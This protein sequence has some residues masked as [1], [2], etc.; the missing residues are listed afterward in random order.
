[1]AI[2]DEGCGQSVIRELAPQKI[3]VSGQGGCG[4]VAQMRRQ[5]CSRRG[6]FVNLLGRGGGM[7]ESHMNATLY[8]GRY[9]INCAGLLRG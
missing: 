4:A 3:G 1:M 7:A 8:E 6:G 2:S 5:A 9:V